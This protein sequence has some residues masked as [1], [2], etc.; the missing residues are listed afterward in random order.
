MTTDTNR[1]ER[2]LGVLRLSRETDGSTS[3]E[4]Q[5]EAIE[6]AAARPDRHARV[7]AW[8]EDSGV[9]G[10]LDPFKRPSL[11]PWFAER[12]GDWDTLMIYKID[13]LSRRVAHFSKVLDWCRENG[14]SIVSVSEGIDLSTPMGTVFAHIIAAF[15]QGELDTMRGRVEAAKAKRHTEGWWI[16]GLPPFGYTLERLGDGKGKWLVQHPE[17]AE[18]ARGFAKA[19][20]EGQSLRSMAMELNERK[21]LT[22]QDTISVMAGKPTRGSKWTSDSIREVLKNPRVAGFFTYKGEVVEDPETLKP[23]MVTAEPILDAATWEKVVARLATN[24]RS[25]RTTRSKA[26]LVG[27]GRC[28][29]CGGGVQKAERAITKK[30]G[31]AAGTEYRYVSY[32]CANKSRHGICGQGSLQVPAQLLEDFVTESLLGNL[33]DLPVM[34]RVALTVIDPSVELDKVINRLAMLNEDF[35]AGVYDGEE[36]AEQYRSMRRKLVRRR[37]AL[38]EEAEAFAEQANTYRPTGQTWAD[39]WA[40]KTDEERQEFL[41][42]HGVTVKVFRDMAEHSRYSFWLDLGDVRGMA[43]AAG[44]TAD[45]SADTGGAAYQVPA[46]VIEALMADSGLLW[47]DGKLTAPAN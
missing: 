19:V 17:Y 5:R 38:R 39:M 32:R 44:V 27:V 10:G 8:A 13:R 33:G 46:D 41:K 18:M 12:A 25:A 11:A 42:L 31:P 3:I 29:G 7:V 16:A 23:V 4:R 2:V 26:M 37:D 40:G 30:T 47:V 15:A 36:E 9:S 45:V 21:V 35:L 24:Q 22:W 28:G 1:T 43:A 20:L 6:H 34:E 14:K